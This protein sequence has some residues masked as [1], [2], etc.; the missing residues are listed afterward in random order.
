MVEFKKE[1][2]TNDLYLME[3]NPKFWAS[4]D[5]AIAS[6]INFAEQYLEI[7]PNNSNS[8]VDFKY[9]INYTV[10]KKFQWL[11]R[12]LSSSIF[13]PARLMRVLY[14]FI[15]LKAKNNLHLRDPL[16]TYIYC[17]MHSLHLLRN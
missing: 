1:Y 6:G 8:I 16:C 5:L 2:K 4:H 14:A 15:F 12:D 10:N 9:E 13:R 3:V 7:S 11:A 17:F